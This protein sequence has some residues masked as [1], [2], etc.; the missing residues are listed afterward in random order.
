MK[1][2][3]NWLKQYVDFSSS[4]DEL[5]GRRAILVLEFEE[6]PTSDDGLPTKGT[7]R[8]LR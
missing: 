7:N 6:G 2:T 5:A 3:L 4:A 1:V 8:S